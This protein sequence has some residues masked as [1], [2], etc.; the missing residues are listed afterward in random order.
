MANKDSGVFL[1]KA[2]TASFVSAE[3]DCW[4]LTN[5]Q[6]ISCVVIKRHL[7]LK[8]YRLVIKSKQTLLMI[9]SLFPHIYK[10]F[11]YILGQFSTDV[12]IL[13]GI[14]VGLQSCPV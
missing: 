3:I 4:R 14:T 2:F 9:S 13:L 6:Y 1:T 5:L 11:W 10:S 12:Q 7:H 8:G